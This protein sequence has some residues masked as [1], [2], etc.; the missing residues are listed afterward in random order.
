MQA[1]VTALP[2]LFLEL[3]VDE[4]AFSRSSGAH[5]RYVVAGVSYTERV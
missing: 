2:H 1:R 5:A 3:K 4:S